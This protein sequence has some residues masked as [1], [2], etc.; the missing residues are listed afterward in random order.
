MK[1]GARRQCDTVVGY[2]PTATATSP[3]DMPVTRSRAAFAWIGFIRFG[4]QRAVIGRII[5]RPDAA[6]GHCQDAHPAESG[7]YAFARVRPADSSP[8]A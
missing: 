2:T 3:V 6:A 4:S 1:P 5:A 7:S 8:M